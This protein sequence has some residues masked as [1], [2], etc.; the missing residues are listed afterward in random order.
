MPKIP[1][2]ILIALLVLAPAFLID[3]GASAEK[4]NGILLY[5]IQPFGGC[6]GI[7]LFNYGPE[8]VNMNG[9]VVTDGE[10]TLTFVQ[11]VF[12]KQ[13]M[14]LTIAKSISADDWFS[15]RENVITIDDECFQKKGTFALADA[16]DDV[17]IYRNSVLIDAFCYGNK[18]AD[19]GWTGDPVKITSNKYALRIGPNDTDTSADWIVTKPGLTNNVFDPE[20]FFNAIVTPFS[21]P[22]SRGDPIFREMENA[23][24]E[25]LISIYLLTSQRLVALLC[26]LSSKKGVKVSIILEGNV[27]GTDIGNELSLMRSLVDAGG[28]VYLIND[29][30]STTNKRF[31][32]F[33][34][35]YAVIDSKKVIVTSENWTSG[36]LSSNGSN[37]GWGVV[38]ES[39]EFAEYAKNVFLSDLDLSN[40]DVRPLLDCFPGLKPYQGTLTYAGATEYEE[41]VSFEARV[42]P[43]LSP[44]NSAAAMRYFI[45]NA[46]TRVYSQ[47]MDVGSSYK[48]VTNA[49]P[50]GW[51]S[52]AA[53]RGLD[54]RFILDSSLNGG[55]ND[56]AVG[57]LNRTTG[58][59]AISVNGR[60]SFDTIHNKGLITDD[61]VWV[62]SV[63]W[64][65]GSFNSN[66]E[67]AVVIDSAEVAA[68]FAELFIEDWGINEHTIRETGLEI[69]MEVLSFNGTSVYVFTVSGPERYAYSW[70][71][72]GS[73]NIRQSEINKIVCT[74][75]PA[76]DHTITVTM[77]GIDISASFDYFVAGGKRDPLNNNLMWIA[78]AAG[79]IAAGIASIIIRR[80]NI[81]T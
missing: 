67:F 39:A 36:N 31:A 26:D 61:T 6:E 22:E 19:E 60:P 7:S 5:E 14:R 50:L 49:S 10:G 41:I 17:Y 24:D 4:T 38:V 81:I 52:S 33:H 77:A 72:L 62:G 78:A 53:G 15:C 64:T 57:M 70:D 16:G 29:S 69:T 9:W 56:D 28:E 34:N 12:V 18:R 13:G 25:I 40:G 63:N 20:L 47:Q 43:V 80:R 74:G 55:K 76:G 48:T 68:F 32:Y 46:E 3:G 30:A 59:K 1:H 45:D 71:V 51:M 37:R 23:E 21:F 73:G 44:D 79:L 58:V 75:L 8:T 65:D 54:V 35:K 11:D 27:L 42:M 2:I 66:R